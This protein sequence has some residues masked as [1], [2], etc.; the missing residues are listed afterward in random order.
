MKRKILL[1]IILLI[2]SLVMVLGFFISLYSY[3]RTQRFIEATRNETINQI[4]EKFRVFD[5]LIY[6][7]E[8]DMMDHGTQA[9]N[10]ISKE[11]TEQNAWDNPGDELLQNLTKKYNIDQI[12]LINK[13]GTIYKTTFEP[14]HNFNLFSISDSFTT[15]IKSIYFKDRIFD[16]RLGISNKTGLLNMYL[17]YGPPHSE[18][19]LEISINARDYIE[20]TYSKEYKDYLFYDFFTS[21]IQTNRYIKDLDIYHINQQSKWSFLNLGRQ[22]SKDRDF[23]NRLNQEKSIIIKEKSHFYLYEIIEFEKSHFSWLDKKNVEIHFDFSSFNEFQYQML[24]ILLIIS[25]I[26]GVIFYF[27][28]SY[29]FKRDIIRR[30][31]VIDKTIAEINQE[32]YEVSIPEEG[33]DELTRISKS[34][35]SMSKMILQRM[36]T[37][38]GF[39]PICSSCKKIRDDDGYWAQIEDYISSHSKA[40]FS[41]S[42]C[43]D[44]FNKLYPDI[45]EKDKEVE[46][47]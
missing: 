31:S 8:K 1:Y 15:F 14:D 7:I 6:F 39:L 21:L 11:L 45:N 47:Q 23:I 3:Q 38:H 5:N 4:K 26:I 2:I 44:C 42:L 43:P 28:F 17:Y 18:I 16:Q 32:N 35:N 36:N 33:N 41:H 27:F 29:L 46:E 34:I 25:I 22:F 37:L 30:I 19:I 13:E 24:F 12:Y 10:K 40:T 9:I 20:N